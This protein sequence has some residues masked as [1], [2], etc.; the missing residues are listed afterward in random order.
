M[1]Q[2]DA[3]PG[4][5]SDRPWEDPER[6]GGPQARRPRVKL[7]PWALLALLVAIIIVLCVG[8]VLLVRALRGDGDEE[9]LATQPAGE[10]AEV[11]PTITRRL[12]TATPGLT[13]ELSPGVTP[14][15]TVVLPI[16]TPLVTAPPTEIRPGVEV[17]VEGTAGYGLNLRAEP[18]TDAQLVTNAP[19]GTVLTVLDGPQQADSYTW[20]NVRTP[21]GKEGWGAARWLTLKAE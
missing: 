18:S 20:W 6:R 10:T 13:P 9:G 1:T 14:S 15:D 4:D 19:E 16:E 17:I 2:Y 21:D 5:W 3:G 7:P 12:F 8:L 11:M